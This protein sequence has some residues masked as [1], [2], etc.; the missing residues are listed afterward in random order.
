MFDNVSQLFL[1]QISST[2]R[3]QQFSGLPRG[4]IFGLASRS[5]QVVELDYGISWQPCIH[6]PLGWISVV[7]WVLHLLS[8]NSHYFS[9]HFV[10]SEENRVRLSAYWTATM[11]AVDCGWK[12]S[13]V[14]TE[15]MELPQESYEH[16]WVVRGAHCRDHAAC[17]WAVKTPHPSHRICLHCWKGASTS[18]GHWWFPRCQEL[19][20]ENVRDSTSWRTSQAVRCD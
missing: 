6:K 1:L 16:L 12:V 11:F 3:R 14:G 9:W 18:A 2:Q 5:N 13:R 15:L 8:S 17:V 19:G 10:N 7:L 20:S 4:I